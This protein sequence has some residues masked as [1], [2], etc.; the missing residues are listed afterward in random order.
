MNESTTARLQETIPSIAP[1]GSE[2]SPLLSLSRG[3]MAH[4]SLSPGQTSRAVA[5]RT[6]EEIWYFLCGRGEIWRRREGREEIVRAEAG[7][8]I[9]IPTG[10]EFQFRS[11]GPD[12]LEAIGVTMPPWPGEQEAHPVLGI[13]PPALPQKK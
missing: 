2:V 10:T 5:H 4:F 12:P 1:D 13:W 11:F 7:V 6:V 8:C 9:A 3:S